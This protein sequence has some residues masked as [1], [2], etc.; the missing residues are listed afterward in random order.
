MSDSKNRKLKAAEKELFKKILLERRDLLSSDADSIEEGA[1]NKSGNGMSGELS[2]VPFHMA[3]VGTENY[4]REF[5]LGILENEQE[6]LREIDEAL[7]RLD[8]GS[9]GMC[10][11]CGMDIPLAR[12]RA[13]AYARM[14]IECKEKQEAGKL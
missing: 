2:N 10:E 3:D 5:S 12:L 6:E 13:L 1:L 11:A 4:D 9:Y 7:E 8:Q 14:C